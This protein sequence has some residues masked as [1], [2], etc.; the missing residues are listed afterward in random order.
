MIWEK[1]SVEDKIIPGISGLAVILII[2]SIYIQSKLILFLA[3]FFLVIAFT[4]QHYLKR[5]GDDLYFE[6]TY[7]KK[8]LF[9]NGNGQWVLTFRNEGLPIL[10]GELRIFFDHYVSPEGEKLDPS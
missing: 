2:V 7:L 8:H 10:K 5:A 9:I 4:N 3:I 6:N 1:Y